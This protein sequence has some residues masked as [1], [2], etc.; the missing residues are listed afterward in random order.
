MN[1]DQIKKE[2]ITEFV[3][4]DNLKILELYA[5]WYTKT[6]TFQAHSLK[7]EMVKKIEGMKEEKPIVLSEE[8]G[9]YMYSLAQFNRVAG[10]NQAVQNI[11]N[12]LSQPEL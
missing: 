11:I 2:F 7:E 3:N 6:I 4:P 1:Y 9:G 10:K 8:N 5:D 12:L